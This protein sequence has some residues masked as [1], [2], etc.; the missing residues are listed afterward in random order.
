MRVLIS[1]AGSHGDVLPFVAIGRE[2]LAR[3]H[4]VIFYG[5]PYFRDW[6]TSVGVQFMPISTADEYQ[7]V[8]GEITEADAA[9]A[10]RR[11]TAHFGDIT[12][13]YY[14]AMKAAV[15]PGQTITVS[16][17][18][19]FA[20]RLLRETDGVP[21]AAVHLAPNIIR[22]SILPAR[23]G[24]NWIKADTP[25]WVKRLAYWMADT[26]V[27]DPSFTK[28]LNKLRAELGLPPLK[29]IF[30][31]WIHQADCVVG[32]FPDWYA[33]KQ[34]DWPANLV[35]AGFPLYDQGTPAPLSA[36]LSQFIADGPAPV[37]FSAGTANANAGEFF[38]ASIQA[39]EMAGIRGILLSNFAGQIPSKL[40]DGVMHVDYAPFG[41]LLPKVA[42]FVHHGGIGSTSQALKAGVPQLIRPVA[43]D[44]FDNAAR[45]VQ[46]G[47]AIELLPKQY[48]ASTAAA[49]L[50]KLMADTKLQQRCK[51]VAGR[52]AAV[53][54]IQTACDAILVRTQPRPTYG[55][56]GLD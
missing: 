49:A 46:L 36:E 52:F 29:R 56:P 18:A 25:A 10:L 21:C 30:E 50:T 22:S 8:F 14:N 27:L 48:T 3:G 28:P 35:L 6:V 55:L 24:A 31:S 15:I 38:A 7:R 37:A 34:A 45:A 41:T 16:S 47:V 23:S 54:A 44:Q 53:D 2:M 5:N 12:R 20:A 39:C 11:I 33:L 42:A 19:F 32:L 26:L 43:Y 1:S 13:D 51:A 9:K 40:P 4:E 17:S